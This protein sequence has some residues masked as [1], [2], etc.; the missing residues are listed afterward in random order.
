MVKNYGE[1]QELL[2]EQLERYKKIVLPISEVNG[3]DSELLVR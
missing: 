1:V 2:A 3:Y